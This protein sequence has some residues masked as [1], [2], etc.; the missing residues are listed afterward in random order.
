MLRG[1]IL[2]AILKAYS[3]IVLI[4]LHFRRLGEASKASC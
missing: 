3:V 1:V 4:V 2:I